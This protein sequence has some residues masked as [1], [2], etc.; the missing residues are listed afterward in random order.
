MKHGLA[1]FQ[2]F[3][4]G[5]L[6]AVLAACNRD[7]PVEPGPVAAPASSVHTAAPAPT[8]K[9]RYIERM[10]GGAKTADE[11]P[12]ILAIHGLGDR[13]ESFGGIFDGFS[14]PARLILPYG[15]T[16]YG[17]GFSWFPI[18]RMD[19]KILADGTR[20]AADELAV[21][22]RDLTTSRPI[23]GKPIVTG[24]SQGGML[25]FTLA[26]LHPDHVGE[27]LPIA[28][29]LAP[30]LYPAAWPMGKVAP[31]VQAFHG[32]ADD[33]VPI[34]GA[35][36]TVRQLTKNG[37]SATLEEYPN[38]RHTVSAQMRQ[39]WMIALKNAVQRAASP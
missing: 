26:V 31:R 14:A 11:V 27:A 7:K 2:S 29:L 33:R 23:K 3:F 30:P 6:V 15:L 4:M 1:R 24:F 35:R 39:D 21:L 5:A 16:S 22:L 10:T 36:E 38:I 9:I 8:S 13:P 37:F 34:E 18:S 17:D 25:S 20:L 19:P 12:V 32:D 28:G